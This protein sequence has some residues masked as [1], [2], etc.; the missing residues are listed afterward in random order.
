MTVRPLPTAPGVDDEVTPDEAP[1]GSPR[2]LEGYRVGV[3]AARKV[4]EQIALL[5]RR[6]AQVEWAPVALQDPNQ[7]DDAELR[8]ATERLLAEPVDIFVA[9]TGIGMRT[10]FEATEAWGLHDALVAAI[11]A[12]EVLARGPKSVGALRRRGI[13]ELWSPDSECFEDVLAHLRG[14]DLRRPA[15]RRA[16]AR[17]VAVDG[18]PRAAAPGRARRRGHG[19]PG[20]ERRG[21]R[22]DVPD[23]RP[24]RRPRA[25]RR[26]LHLR[27][28]GRPR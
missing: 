8:A 1:T 13:R 26:H 20:A 6:G 21:P 4:D 10:W 17:P 11:G 15:H 18:R 27:P 16:G 14:R 5:E 12:A 9:T 28:R 22:A 3:T 7:V 2:P 23:G 25:R 24:D 19:L